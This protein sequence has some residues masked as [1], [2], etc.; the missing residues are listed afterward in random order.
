MKNI[1]NDF[2][3]YLPTEE[4]HERLINVKEINLEDLKETEE[5]RKQKAYLRN[6]SDDDFYKLLSAWDLGK[7]LLVGNSELERDIEQFGGKEELFEK[8]AEILKK[9]TFT[10]ENAIDWFMGIDGSW[11]RKCLDEFQDKY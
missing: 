8:N 4:K 7:S 10:K 5:E 3:S 2:K 6:L 9:N 1:I 11:I